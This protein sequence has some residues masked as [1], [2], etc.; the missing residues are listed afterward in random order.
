MKFVRHAQMSQSVL[1]SSWQQKLDAYQP[2]LV[3]CHNNRL[4]TATITQELARRKIP[5]ISSFHD[6]D[7]LDFLHKPQSLKAQIK[8][9][10]FDLIRQTSTYLTAPTHRMERELKPFHP[11][12]T[13]LP[14]FID[15]MDWIASDSP[16]IANKQLLYIGRMIRAKGIFRLLEALKY[17]EDYHLTCVGDG[18]DLASFRTE[19]GDCGLAERVSILGF[20]SPSSLRKEISKA[21]CLLLAS[22]YREVFG[23]VGIEAQAMGLPCIASD[24]G[25]IAEWCKPNKTGLLIKAADTPELVRNIQFLHSQPSVYARLK[26]KGLQHQKQFFSAEAI[27]PQLEQLY[28]FALTKK[29][30][31]RVCEK[32][33]KRRLPNQRG[34]MPAGNSPID[35]RLDDRHPHSVGQDG[36]YTS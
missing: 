3:H 13:Y 6:Y 35:Y 8:K 22:E 34:Y 4:Y 14:Y 2:D 12:V 17:L 15:N 30:G 36:Y 29:A 23:I 25:G 18:P 32:S 21:S 1:R 26:K 33:Q 19:V 27:M 31:Y 9:R 24:V 20:R 7:L 28:Q 11:R 10:Q 16:R 5:V